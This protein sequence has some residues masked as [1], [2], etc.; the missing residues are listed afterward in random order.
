FQSFVR[1]SQQMEVWVAME[2][3]EKR[4]EMEVK[5]E[6]VVMVVQAVMANL[7]AVLLFLRPVVFANGMHRHKLIFLLLLTDLSAM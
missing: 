4:E 2:G 6:R 7:V 5:G 3:M 1:S